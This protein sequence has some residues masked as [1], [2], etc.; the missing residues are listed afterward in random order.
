LLDE[1][2]LKLK[3]K[4]TREKFLKAGAD[5]VI[6]NMNELPLIINRIN[7]RLNRN[8]KPGNYHV[9]PEQP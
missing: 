1:K 4:E 9:F 5:Y 3:V 6:E 7:E 2:I 8:E